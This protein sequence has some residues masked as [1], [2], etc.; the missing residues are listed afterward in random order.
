MG[1]S[2]SKP[3]KTGLK[4]PSIILEEDVARHLLAPHLVGQRI[5]TPIDESAFLAA[6]EALTAL[7]PRMRHYASSF[8]TRSLIKACDDFHDRLYAVYCKLPLH[9]QDPTD[10]SRILRQHRGRG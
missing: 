1:N 7:E 8:R 5:P 9:E 6:L 10:A 3:P 2:S 4:V